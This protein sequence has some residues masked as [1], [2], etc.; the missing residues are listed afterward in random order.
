MKQK[1]EQRWP[2]Q[3]VHQSTLVS[4][5]PFQLRHSS[6]KLS[7]YCLS[8]VWSSSFSLFL[9]LLRAECWTQCPVHARQVHYTGTYPQPDLLFHTLS[10]SLVLGCGMSVHA[11]FLPLSPQTSPYPWR[12][13]RTSQWEE[14]FS[15][16]VQVRLLCFFI[17]NTLASITI[18]SLYFS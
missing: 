2:F 6:I 5:T 11:N 4:V 16:T 12:C 7:P 13:L 18:T 17:F 15:S 10:V 1:W 3:L 8:I 9:P 14:I